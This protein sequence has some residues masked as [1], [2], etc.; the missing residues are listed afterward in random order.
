[1]NS[2]ASLSRWSVETPG[3][4]MRDQH[5]QALGGQ[6]AGAAHALEGLGLVDLDLTRA[7]LG[8]DLD[9]MWRISPF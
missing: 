2:R 9:R 1:M 6:L 8:F 7:G 4:D 5:V 3:H